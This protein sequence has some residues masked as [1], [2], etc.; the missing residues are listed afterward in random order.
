MNDPGWIDLFLLYLKLPPTIVC[1]NIE[2]LI[3]KHFLA[4][5]QELGR[6]LNENEKKNQK[7][8]AVILLEIR[9]SF[10]HVF[11]RVAV[12]KDFFKSYRK[13]TCLDSFCSKIDYRTTT[14]LITNLSSQPKFTCSKSTWKH[15]NNV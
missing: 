11:Y 10:F 12:P 4:T 9:S 14:L 7:N 6:Y 15:K 13:T 3:G 2:N 8:I 5:W 1:K